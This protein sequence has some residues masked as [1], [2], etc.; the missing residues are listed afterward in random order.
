MSSETSAIAAVGGADPRSAAITFIT[1]EHFT[2]R[3]ARAA[4]IAESTGRA[5][6]FLE[7]G[8]PGPSECQADGWRLQDQDPVRPA[9]DA[10]AAVEGAAKQTAVARHAA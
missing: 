9:R 6:M 3:G 4:T 10:I 1:T 5:R 7:Q 2:L 8:F